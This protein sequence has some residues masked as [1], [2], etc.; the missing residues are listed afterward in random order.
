MHTDKSV[1]LIDYTEKTRELKE[2]VLYI[3]Y[4]DY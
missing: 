1:P 4:N 3:P 2:D